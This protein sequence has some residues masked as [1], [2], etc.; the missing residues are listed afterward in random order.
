MVISVL[1][2]GLC[3]SGFAQSDGWPPAEESLRVNE[4]YTENTPR[5][6]VKR[7]RRYS[8]KTSLD[9]RSASIRGSTEPISRP[10]QHEDKLNPIRKQ[11]FYAGLAY[12]GA[13]LGY[14]TES[15]AFELRGFKEGEIT[16]YGPRFTHYMFPFKGGN[17]YWGLDA[18]YIDSFEGT[19]TEGD[20]YMGTGFLGLQKYL[21]SHF[22]FNVDAG[23]SFIQVEDDLSGVKV[24]GF[25]FVVNTSLNVH[26]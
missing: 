11:S 20:G 18:H 25:E 8:L 6:S 1:L 22:S 3:S 9:Q 10:N 17:F 16:I 21:G 19:I 7:S 15:F 26:F 2:V 12:P 23:P 14:Q 5:K 13:L 24:D 4:G